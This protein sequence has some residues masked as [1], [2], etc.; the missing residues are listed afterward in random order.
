M[1]ARWGASRWRRQV[2]RVKKWGHDNTDRGVIIHEKYLVPIGLIIAKILCFVNV[3]L[4]NIF[5][6][7]WCDAFVASSTASF[8]WKFGWNRQNKNQDNNYFVNAGLDLHFQK[9]FTYYDTGTWALQK[10]RRDRGCCTTLSLLIW[11]FCCR[12]QKRSYY[13]W[14]TAIFCKW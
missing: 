9:W 6:V 14:D 1:R 11:H 8:W 12:P 7:N 3:T 4:F 10:V 2:S 13:R 5:K